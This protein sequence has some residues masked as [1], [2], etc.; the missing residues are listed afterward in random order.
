TADRLAARVTGRFRES[1]LSKVS[2]AVAD[3]T[4]DAVAT[5]ERI[6]TPNWWLRIGLAVLALAIVAVAALVA[7]YVSSDARVHEYVRLTSG[8][9]VWLGAAVVFFWTL[10]TRFKRGKAV[11]AIHDLRA[12]AHIIDM[13]QLSKDPECGPDSDPKYNREALVSYL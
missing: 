9:A 3:V 8:A 5:A 7:T 2:V 4:R 10:E 1:G 12:L 6:N 11:K 13:H